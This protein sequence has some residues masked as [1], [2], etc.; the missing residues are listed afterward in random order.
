MNKSRRNGE[1]H[2]GDTWRVFRIMGEFVEGFETMSQIGTAVTIFG[3]ARTDPEDKYYQQ[4]E[5]LAADLVER[6]FAVITGGGPGIMEAANKGATAADGISVGLN[7]Q[8]PMEQTPNPFSNVSVDFHYFFAR[9][10]MFVKY[11]SALVCFPGGYGTLDEF[12]E[13]LTLI[14]TQRS[15]RYPVVCI[16]TEYWS[17]LV[18]WCKEV[19]LKKYSCI[20]DEDLFIFEVTDDIKAAA[21]FIEKHAGSEISDATRIMSPSGEFEVAPRR[22]ERKKRKRAT[23]RPEGL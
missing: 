23:H 12:F 9:K 13:S 14:Q 18:D 17:G 6:D 20:S 10:M 5:Q 11:A 2:T 19:V 4:A 1:F 3:S 16:G 15:P 22:I 7:I 8:L 21:D